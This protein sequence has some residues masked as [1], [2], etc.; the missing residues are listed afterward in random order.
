MDKLQ[1][2]GPVVLAILDGVGL[3]PDGAGN[4]VSR[5]RTPFLGKA[6]RDYLILK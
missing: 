1:F 5:A 4:A 6:V 2:D 3:A